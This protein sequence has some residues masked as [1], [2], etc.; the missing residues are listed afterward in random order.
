MMN[1]TADSNSPSSPNL[2]KGTLFCHFE[3]TAS[4]RLS[5]V[6]GVL[7]KPGAIHAH[8]ILNIPSSLLHVFV[9]ASTAALEAAYADCPAFP[10][11][12]IELM[13]MITPFVF[14][15]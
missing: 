5:R 9:S 10:C 2:P 1:S 14:V 4:L 13:L 8:L 6:D 11:A 7:K 12:E 3:S 15:I